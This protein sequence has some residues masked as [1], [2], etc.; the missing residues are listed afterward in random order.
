[1]GACFLGQ[2]VT[3]VSSLLMTR[4]GLD[5]LHNGWLVD[6]GIGFASKETLGSTPTR[7]LKS[8]IGFQALDNIA[9]SKDRFVAGACL[10][11][12]S[13]DG[14]VSMFV[15]VL[16]ARHGSLKDL[17]RICPFTCR[18][19]IFLDKFE[20]SDELVD[21]RSRGNTKSCWSMGLREC[22]EEL[23]ILPFG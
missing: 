11:P 19:L 13:L 6:P 23:V 17:I 5:K 9:E 21:G 8:T 22:I 18:D 10:N 7:K 14:V 15:P 1:M 3:P 20:L 4:F 2:V 12:L 16:D